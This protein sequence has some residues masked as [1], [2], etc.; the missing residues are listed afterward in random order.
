M[1]QQSEPRASETGSVADEAIKLMESLGAWADTQAQAQA[2][3]SAQSSGAPAPDTQEAPGQESAEK[4]TTGG[5]DCSS[6]HAPKV[7]AVCPVCRIGSFVE[8]LGPDAME[9][10]ADVIGMLAGSLQEAARQRRGMPEQKSAAEAQQP[11]RTHKVPVTT[12]AG[13]DPDAARPRTGGGDSAE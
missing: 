1:N 10:I 4:S 8:S 13:T 9:R 12:D 5:C 11:P 3:A 7:C 2:Q 6:T